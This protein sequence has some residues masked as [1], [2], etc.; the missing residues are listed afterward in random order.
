MMVCESLAGIL[1]DEFSVN[2]EMSYVIQED[3][4][5]LKELCVRVIPGN[6]TSRL[7]N[8]SSASHEIIVGIVFQKKINPQT[9]GTALDQLT[10]LV[11]QVRDFI[12]FRYVNLT[13]ENGDFELRN[14]AIE[15]NPYIDRDELDSAR[16]LSVLQLTYTIESEVPS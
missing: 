4:R 16:F 7:V 10:G 1:N 12:E 14:T 11:R 8:R 13:V 2:A 15:H 5:S 3:V 9:K 6:F